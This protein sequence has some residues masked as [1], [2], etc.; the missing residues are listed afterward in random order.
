MA[1]TETEANKDLVR[2]ESVELTENKNVDAVDDLYAEDVR[3]RLT[4][5]GTDD[6]VVS[7]EDVK[8]LYREWFSAFPDLA[9]VS[10]ALV[11]E[12]DEVM[13]YVTVTGTHEGTFRGIEPTGT[14]IEVDG[15][16]YRRVEDGKITEMASMVGMT[17][18]FSQ[19]GV[20]VPIED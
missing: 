5:T 1:T 17:S 13:E 20:D 10:H 6:L 14:R 16:H 18:L 19:L 7:R 9:E 8:S 11:A 15:Y 12:G 4:R 2:R 3:V